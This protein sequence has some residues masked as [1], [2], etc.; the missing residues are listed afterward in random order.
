MG[1]KKG[2]TLIETIVVIA[3]IGLTIPAIFAI[4]FGLVR[5]QAKINRLSEVKRQGDYVLNN[6][7]VLI[8]NNALSV[9]SASPA[10]DANEKC[11]ID[12]STYNSNS[13]LYFLDKNGHW[14]GFRLTTNKISSVSVDLATPVDLTTTKVIISGLNIGCGKTTLYSPA[15]VSLSFDICYNTGAGICTST[16]PEET[17]TLHYQ[18]KIKLRNL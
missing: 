5:Q 6:I 4:I 10:T 7:A 15:T 3:V 9:H 17:A 14:F 18:T 16:H 11:S 1:I 8:R 12:G 13:S 2:F